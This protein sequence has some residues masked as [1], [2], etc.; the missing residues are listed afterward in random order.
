[1]AATQIVS[2]LVDDREPHRAVLA[3][4]CQRPDVEIQVVRLAVGD[5]RVDEALLFER[6]T[7]PDLAV[8][9]Q[10]G[11]LFAQALRLVRAPLPAALILEG[12]TRDLAACG[13][14][15]EAIQGALV[16]LTLFMGLPLLRALDPAETATLIVTAARQGR[17]V[18]SG[19]LPRPGR[20]P[21]GKTRVQNRILQGLPGVGPE[22][23]RRLLERFGTVEA[24]MAAPA[25][26]L[27]AVSG[28]GTATA[29]LI[30]WAVGEDA[31]DYAPVKPADALWP[32]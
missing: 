16:T 13:M 23:A 2:I 3:A 7:L 31:A 8:S 4:L 14:R 26:E 21:R 15:R 6:K 10:D 29:H 24:V 22:R 9:I 28:I 11:R 12:T 18:A 20:R 25:A 19:A 30:R 32:L 27:M 17:A 5:Y 1:M